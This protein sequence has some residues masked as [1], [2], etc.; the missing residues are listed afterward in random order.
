MYCL[1]LLK[2]RGFHLP[3]TN[4]ATAQNCAPV[5]ES[6]HRFP[7]RSVR[8]Y[9][10]VGRGLFF[11]VTPTKESHD[12]LPLRRCLNKSEDGARTR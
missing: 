7:I 11:S 9:R 3:C 4:S 10:G 8:L 5:R 2:F 6:H 12:L 1:L